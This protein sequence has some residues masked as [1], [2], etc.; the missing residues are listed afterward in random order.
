MSQ[1][2]RGG[3]QPAIETF[4]AQN[5]HPAKVVALYPKQA[6]SGNLYVPRED[7]MSL[8]GAVEGA[9]LEPPEP[10]E[11]APEPGTSV[12]KSLFNAHLSLARKK[13]NET[14]RS[15]SSAAK[16]DRSPTPEGPVVGKD[17]PGNSNEISR[18]AIDELIYFLSDRR[19]KLA[20][21]IPALGKPLPSEADMVPLSDMPAK[22]VHEL[23][24]VPMT[25]LDAEQ[26]LRTAQVVYTSLLKVY[27]VARPTLVGSL[28][29]I[30]NW[31]DVAEVEPL[32]REK[33]VSL[34][35]RRLE[36]TT[37]ASTIFGTCTCRRTCTTRPSVCC[38]SELTVT[39]R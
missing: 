37:S 26:L 22:E 4:I 8:F 10:P 5:V 15:V 32:L 1:F 13:S 3:Y 9:R 29:R 25:E 36:L 28:C 19:Q 16:D 14:I 17:V 18:A 23:P 24:D 30:E 11:P 38:T 21:A 34:A 39:Q 6:I 20:G 7:W 33:G 27:L 31:C 35:R 12:P 2:A